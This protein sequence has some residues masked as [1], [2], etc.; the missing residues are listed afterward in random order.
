[1]EY[2]EDKVQCGKTRSILSKYCPSAYL[3]G[4]MFLICLNNISYIWQ[5]LIDD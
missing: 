3:F 2:V 1:M 4:I 5:I